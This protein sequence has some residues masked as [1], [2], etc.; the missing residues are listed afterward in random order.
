MST[1]IGIHI[2]R[3]G[4]ILEHFQTDRKVVFFILEESLKD[5]ALELW[6]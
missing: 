4:I 3:K 6:L 5:N 2:P 1:Y